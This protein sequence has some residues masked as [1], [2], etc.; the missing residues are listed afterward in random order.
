MGIW[1]SWTWEYSEN[2]LEL[3]NRKYLISKFD[4]GDQEDVYRYS[5]RA[6]FRNM[7]EYLNINTN[8]NINLQGIFTI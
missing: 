6:K 7:Y 5:M 2:C 8:Q 1:I 4:R 3:W